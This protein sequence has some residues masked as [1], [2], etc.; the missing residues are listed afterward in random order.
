MIADQQVITTKNRVL[1]ESILKESTIPEFKACSRGGP[2]LCHG[3]DGLI[4]SARLDP[5]DHERNIQWTQ[6]LPEAMHSFTT[7]R[8]N[9]NQIGTEIEEGADRIN[10]A[11]GPNHERLVTLKNK[12]DPTNLF[13]HNQNIK[14]MV[15]RGKT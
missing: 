6:K 14:P 1:K 2:L 4:Q 10:A 9:I 7:G 13:R 3:D 8:G 15:Q 11:Y 5:A 12:Y